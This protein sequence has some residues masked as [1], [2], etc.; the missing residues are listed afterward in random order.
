MPG[1]GL[2]SGLAQGS[3]TIMQ[4]QAQKMQGLGSIMNTQANVYNTGQER[5]AAAIAGL[6]QAAGMVGGFAA[7]GYF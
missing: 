5:E 1:Q 2:Q 3:G 4:G 7:G 6:G